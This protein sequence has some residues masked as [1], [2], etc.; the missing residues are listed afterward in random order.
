MTELFSEYWPILKEVRT[1]AENFSKYKPTTIRE[2]LTSWADRRP[3]EAP[4][5]VMEDLF[6]SISPLKETM[7]LI[8]RYLRDRDWR[9]AIVRVVGEYGSGK[10]Q[11]GRM[12][13][14]AIRKEGEAEP[15]FISIDPLTDIG[16]SLAESV[17]T[18]APIVLIVDEVDQLLRDLEK[19][20]REKLEDLADAVRWITEGSYSSPARGSVILLLSKRAQEALMSDRS[21][22][23]RLLERSRMFRLSMSDEEREK[24]G[25]EAAKKILALWMTYSKSH[26]YLL[27]RIFPALYPLM[28]KFA[29]DLALTREI[30]GIIKNLVDLSEEVL[31][32]VREDA[33]IPSKLEEGV[34]VESLLREF[35][36][37]EMRSFPFRVRLGD[38][39]LDY[40]AIFSEER[41]AVNGAISDGQFLIWTYDPSSGRRG[42]RLVEK[43]GVEVKF[44]EYWMNSRDQIIRLLEAHPLL[45][46]SITNTD[47]EELSEVE[48]EI[49]RGGHSFA[50]LPVNPSL[51]R[52]AHLLRKEDALAFIREKGN[53]ERDLPEA[54]SQLMI[55]SAISQSVE[56]TGIDRDVLLRKASS[57]ILSSLIRELKK[58]K[59][60]KRISTLSNVIMASVDSV[61]RGAGVEA[62]SMSPGTVDMVIR[63]F[64]REGIGRV[65]GTG[66]SLVLNREA[67]FVL[68]EVEKDEKRR[69]NV[70]LVIYDVLSKGMVK[71]APLS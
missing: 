36:S 45:L 24:A 25:V 18:N 59:T 3:V 35:L 12:L 27:E 15:R 32:N 13:L 52:V 39:R 61:F 37:K 30:G 53:F 48:A 41:L 9:G 4:L 42:S 44:G 6:V 20:K 14:R 50:V 65:S 16:H 33:T 21:L 67:R 70:E 2:V 28:E 64:V 10:T 71:E 38:E 49:R 31:T 34:I 1:L 57:A 23:N 17:D 47:P 43:I 55:P 22:A 8:L 54:L 69:K 66:K 7:N 26:A 56:E 19:G 40:I 51:M 46:L 11:L 68:N 60:Y 58:A 62:P 5:E 63:V 29:K